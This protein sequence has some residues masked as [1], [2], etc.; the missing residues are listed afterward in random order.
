[1]PTVSESV[2]S[3]VKGM[4]DIIAYGYQEFGTNDRYMVLRS[5]NT[6]EAGCRFPYIESVIPFGYQ[7]LIDAINKAIDEEERIKGM[8]AVTNEKRTAV[9]PATFNY[10]EL[11]DEFNKLATEKMQLDAETYQPKITYII[12]KY[13][14]RG[15]KFSEASRD[16]VEQMS[17]IIDELKE[18]K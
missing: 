5:D 4:S 13:L 1:M 15:R 11:V 14:G 17:L 8:S 6:I 3:I 12:E 10:E 16:Q 7:H 18:L 9:G 2:N